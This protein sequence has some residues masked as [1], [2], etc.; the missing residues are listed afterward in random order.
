MSDADDVAREAYAAW[1]LHEYE[2]AADLFYHAA[3]LEREAASRRGPDAAPDQSFLH[4]F[5]AGLCLWELGR[6]DQARPVLL[7][8]TA[9]DYKAARLWGDRHDAEKS[10]ARLLM[11]CAARS[12]RER[13]AALWRQATARGDQLS[14]PFPSIIPHQK[15]L[16]VASMSLNFRE[17]CEQVLRQLDREAVRRDNELS[18]LKAQAE[19]HCSAP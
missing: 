13:F 5:R 8:A 3:E 14:F 1:E 17:G 18:V 4:R 19:R 11:E 10:F 9:F 12:D 6:F 16:L 2:Q 7:E 15:Q